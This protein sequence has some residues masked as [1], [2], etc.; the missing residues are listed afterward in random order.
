MLKSRVSTKVYRSL[1]VL[2]DDCVNEKAT[3]YNI[4][5]SKETLIL[6]VVLA[7]EFGPVLELNGSVLS[8]GY[9]VECAELV[10]L[11]AWVDIRC[12]GDDLFPEVGLRCWVYDQLVHLFFA[13]LAVKSYCFP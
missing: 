2:T 6:A 5:T 12:V 10:A 9:V 3:T 11:V 13:L 1:L 4:S 8:C 7:F